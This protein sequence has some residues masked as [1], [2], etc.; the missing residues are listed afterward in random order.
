L[1]AVEFLGAGWGAAVADLGAV[2]ADAWTGPP[3]SVRLEV[4]G[5]PEG[6]T[7]VDAVL[8]SGGPV[9]VVGGTTK[10]DVVVT[11][12]WADAV[13]IADGSLR[14]DTAYMQGR[15]KLAGPHGSV[16]AVLAASATPAWEQA[17][18]RLAAMTTFA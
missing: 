12:G 17:R 5:G 18:H 4:A 8:E 2:P 11:L 6:D 3:T 15:A 7:R 13:A 9:Q 16:L 1:A 14:L 10:P